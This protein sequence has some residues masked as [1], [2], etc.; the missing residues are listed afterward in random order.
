[1]DKILALC[2]LVLT[3]TGWAFILVG[4]PRTAAAILVLATISI[5]AALLKSE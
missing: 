1:M 3:A 4:E 5:V 2:G